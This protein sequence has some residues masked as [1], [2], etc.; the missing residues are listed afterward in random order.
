MKNL[1]RALDALGEMGFLRLGLD[2]GHAEPIEAAAG[3]DKT[4]IVLEPKARGCGGSPAKNAIAWR[5]S[6]FP[7][8]QGLK[9]LERRRAGC[10]MPDP[11]G[12]LNRSRC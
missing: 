4:P 5:G 10:S 11:P 3:A 2:S 9:R 1:E 6:A 8:D 12:G 7:P